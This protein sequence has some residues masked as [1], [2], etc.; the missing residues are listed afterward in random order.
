MENL[1][2]L[3]IFPMRTIWAC[4]GCQVARLQTEGSERFFVRPTEKIWVLNGAVIPFSDALKAA[5]EFAISKTLP[6]CIQ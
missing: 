1:P 5:R 6:K 2:T 3:I 4:I